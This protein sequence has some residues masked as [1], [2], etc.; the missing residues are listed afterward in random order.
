MLYNMSL[1]HVTTRI[2][3]FSYLWCVGKWFETCEKYLGCV[4]HYQ[5]QVNIVYNFADSLD[6]PHSY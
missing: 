1:W 6:E 4:G 5:L 2:S 3:D